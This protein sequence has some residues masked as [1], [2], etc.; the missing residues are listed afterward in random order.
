MSVGPAAAAAGVVAVAELQGMQ[1]IVAV[2]EMRSVV[3]ATGAGMLE[4]AAAGVESEMELTAFDCVFVS[5]GLLE[6]RTVFDETQS[7]SPA[8]MS[9]FAFVNPMIPAL[10]VVADFGVSKGMQG[11]VAVVGV[12]AA[13]VVVV[14]SAA[15]VLRS[16][17]APA[18]FGAAMLA[19]ETSTLIA[20]RRR[21]A[22][23]KETAY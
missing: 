17:A 6:A 11:L 5:P 2:V 20:I 14:E 16:A 13:A 1:P 4:A 15:E 9:G 7:C 8:L 23:E 22:L 21:T 12:A 10:I 18:A 3:A 19:A